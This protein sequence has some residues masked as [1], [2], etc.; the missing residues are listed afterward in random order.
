MTRA[1]PAFLHNSFLQNRL[2][3]GGLL[4]VFLG[5]AM[6]SAPAAEKTIS[7][8]GQTYYAAYHKAEGGKSITEFLPKGQNLDSWVRLVS[9]RTLPDEDNPKLAALGLVR[10]LKY[11]NPQAQSA[12]IQHPSSKD[13]IVD[14]VTWPQDGKFIEFNIFRYSKLAKNKGLL[15]QQYAQRAY[16]DKTTDFLASLRSERQRLV[17]LMVKDGLIQQKK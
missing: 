14:F 9:L 4:P 16:G 7:F 5:L 10:T 13:V 2:F 12:M 3:Y 8:D 11:Q 17:N 1:A 15:L 6:T